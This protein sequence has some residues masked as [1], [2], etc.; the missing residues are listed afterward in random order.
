IGLMKNEVLDRDGIMKAYHDCW[1]EKE[2]KETIQYRDGDSRDDCIAQ[3]V[4]LIELYLNEPPPERIVAVEQRFIAPLFNSQG[5]Y[6]ETPLV[7]ITDLITATD[8][9]LIVNEFKTSGRAYGE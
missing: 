9:H 6:L 2:A 5:E 8:D 7:A 1:N 3:G 4:H